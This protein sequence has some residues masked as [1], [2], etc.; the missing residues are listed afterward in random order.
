MW[1]RLASSHLKTLAT[2]SA[3][4]S[5]SASTSVRSTQFLLLN[6]S[7]SASVFIRY[8]S[9]GSVDG[10][11]KKRVEDVM[12]IATGHEREELEAELEGKKLLD[13]D[14]PEGPFGTKV[15]NKNLM[16]Y[17]S[18]VWFSSL[19][20]SG[21]VQFIEEEPSVIKSYYDKRI[22][23]CPGGEGGGHLSFLFLL[24]L[25]ELMIAPSLN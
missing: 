13:I 8:L 11:V 23:G 6:R 25:F 15:N 20:E 24:F 21:L 2:A 5:T 14:F 22:V 7:P 18:L 3:A 16:A 10:A 1:R 12:P 4:A 9:A 17:G 19:K